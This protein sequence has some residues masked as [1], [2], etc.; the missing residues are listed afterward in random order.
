[1]PA[2]GF[3]H[4][5][6]RANKELTAKL[7]D[8]YVGAIGL[9]EGWRPPFDFPGHWLY[10]GEH[11]VLHLV[12][13]ES[14]PAPASASNKT[15]DHVAFT[16]SELSAFEEHLRVSRLAVRRTEVPGT[17]QVQLFLCDPAGIGVELNFTSS[18]A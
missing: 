14:I 5:N 10:V 13:D 1:M 3:N 2:L 7:R 17:T 6:L 8:F 4:F 18:D 11:A 15:F 9:H 12:E 16:C